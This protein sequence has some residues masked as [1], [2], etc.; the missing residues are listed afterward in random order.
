MF[1]PFYQ[2]IRLEGNVH[3]QSGEEGSLKNLILSYLIGL[4]A[5]SIS[6]ALRSQI[7]SLHPLNVQQP[8]DSLALCTRPCIYR[9][10][11]VTRG[12]IAQLTCGKS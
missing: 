8:L 7:I 1:E 4:S 11:F 9:G 10:L 6:P 5:F 3:E 2:V 12:R